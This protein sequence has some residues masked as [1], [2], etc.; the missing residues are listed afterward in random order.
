MERRRRERAAPFD[1]LV[2][3]SC[4]LPMDELRAS[5]TRVVGRLPS[6]PTLV[7]FHDWHEHDGYVSPSEVVEAATLAEALADDA[8]MLHLSPEDSLVARAW[9][10]TDSA[11]LLRWMVY[12]PEDTDSEI[13]QGGR[14]DLTADRALIESLRLLVPGGQTHP[15]GVYFEQRR[16]R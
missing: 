4:D 3:A 8:S 10:P 11:F 9:Y 16:G 15:A 12:P 6:S 1:G 7:T 5:V 2:I 13:G 14:V